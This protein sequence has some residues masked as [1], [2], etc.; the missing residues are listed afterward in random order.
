MG[1]RFAAKPSVLPGE[2]SR[3]GLSTTAQGQANSLELTLDE[4]LGSG[5]QVVQTASGAR[6]QQTR[7]TVRPGQVWRAIQQ[8]H[9]GW[10]VRV[11][12]VSASKV[13]FECLMGPSHARKQRHWMQRARFLRD[14]QQR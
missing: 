4:A 1:V 9:L 10:V 14:F 11:R 5:R 7:P 3:T 2:L 13:Y 12:R 6:G 8:D